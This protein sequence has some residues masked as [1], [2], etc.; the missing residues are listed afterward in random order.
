MYELSSSLEEMPKSPTDGESTA[1]LRHR[2]QAEEPRPPPHTYRA[3]QSAKSPTIPTI[4]PSAQTDE[5]LERGKVK[6]LV[7]YYNG[8]NRAAPPV[9]DL[10]QRTKDAMKPKRV[11]LSAPSLMFR[12]QVNYQAS[13]SQRQPLPISLQDPHATR[14]SGFVSGSGSSKGK[15]TRRDVFLPLEAW[16]IGVD[17]TEA[18]PEPPAN[19]IWERDI[20]R[21]QHVDSILF[22]LHFPKR[23][24]ENVQYVDIK[25]RN[26]PSGEICFTKI[27]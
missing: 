23:S 4:A 15:G 12:N 26:A 24:L 13:Q 1:R 5:P 3:S 6:E 9:Y 21:L 17:I 7:V 27:S 19:L 10:R 16:S 8:V 2:N 22:E 11:G 25:V 18:T 14:P 20:L